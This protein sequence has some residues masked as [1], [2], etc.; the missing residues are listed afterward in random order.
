M[1]ASFVC[2]HPLVMEWEQDSV[3]KSCQ[4]T[5]N[6]EPLEVL[7]MDYKCWALAEG[8][9]V[10]I[11][12]KKSY[13]NSKFKNL[14]ILLKI[15]TYVKILVYLQSFA[16]SM[17]LFEVW[18]CI[19]SYLHR[20]FKLSMELRLNYLPWLNDTFN[21]CSKTVKC[22]LWMIKPRQKFFTFE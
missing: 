5:I 13:K 11:L 19:R 4:Q 9:S 22:K 6:V 2:F 12:F 14:K 10:V 20:L 15:N 7:P 8:K 18:F 17:F 21:H 1:Q 3:W 16:Q